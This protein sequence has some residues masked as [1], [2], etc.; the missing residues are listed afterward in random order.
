MS[1][2]LLLVSRNALNAKASGMAV[3]CPNP[4]PFQKMQTG[5]KELRPRQVPSR[6][7]PKDLLLTAA[8]NF[9]RNNFSSWIETHSHAKQEHCRSLGWTEG[10][11]PS[12]RRMH[13]SSTSYVSSSHQSLIFRSSPRCAQRLR[14]VPVGSPVRWRGPHYQLELSASLDLVIPNHRNLERLSIQRC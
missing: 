2:T 1:P 8:C 5:H 11:L 4:P 10:F 9:V 6:A 7:W 14:G 13:R 12:Q 3:G